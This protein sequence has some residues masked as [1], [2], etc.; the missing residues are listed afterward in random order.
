MSKIIHYSLILLSL[1]LS[2]TKEIYLPSRPNRDGELPIIQLQQQQQQQQSEQQQHHPPSM[3][4]QNIKP[5][6]S[7]DIKQISGKWYGNE[8]IMHTQDLPGVYQYD[9]CVIVHINDVTEQMHDYN[10]HNYRVPAPTIMDSVSVTQP[11]DEYEPLHASVR[12]LRL[13]WNEKDLNIEYIFNY[14][15][16]RPGLWHNMGE[17]RGSMVALNQYTQFSGRIQV[18]NSINDHLVLTFCGS[19]MHHSIYT[20]VLSRNPDGLNSVVCSRK[21]IQTIRSIRNLLT[22]R[23]LYTES[24]RKVCETTSS[25]GHRKMITLL[26]LSSVGVLMRI[27][28]MLQ[29]CY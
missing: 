22:R 26:K 16:N 10:H 23:G 2:D 5:Q 15:M 28:S 8:I 1:S 7:V 27:F 19:D 12:Y 29:K 21:L 14:T 3:L 25:S 11:V 20:I 17:Q 9:S 6:H 24:I 18:V 4:C 13:I